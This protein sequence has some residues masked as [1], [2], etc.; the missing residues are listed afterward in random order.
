MNP[1]PNTKAVCVK[2]I[3]CFSGLRIPSLGHNDNQHHYDWNN[4]LRLGQMKI[5]NSTR[6]GRAGTHGNVRSAGFS[7]R[8]AN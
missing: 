6:T 1:Q 2:D 8:G 4:R 3:L 5:L 7:K